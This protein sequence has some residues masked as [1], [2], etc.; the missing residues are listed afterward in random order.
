M[1]S[2]E[3]F[4]FSVIL[5]LCAAAVVVSGVDDMQPTRKQLRECAALMKRMSG[6]A[7]NATK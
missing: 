4:G 6:E 3:A 5:I 2:L 7:T 1:S